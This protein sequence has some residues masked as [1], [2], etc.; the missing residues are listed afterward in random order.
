MW[1]VSAEEQDDTMDG[2]GLEERGAADMVRVC[3]VPHTGDVTG[4]EVM[5]LSI[6]L[7]RRRVI[8]ISQ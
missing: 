8:K 4:L 7:E 1:K 2:T 6:L 5:H 3:E